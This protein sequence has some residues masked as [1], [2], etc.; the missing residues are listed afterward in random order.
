[1]V[2]TLFGRRVQNG[3]ASSHF[4]TEGRQYCVFCCFYKMKPGNYGLN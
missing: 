3:S 2:L 4:S 1:M